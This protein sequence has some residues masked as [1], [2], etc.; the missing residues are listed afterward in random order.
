MARLWAMNVDFDS[1]A[2]GDT[3]PVLI[4]WETE[5]TIERYVSLHG[6]WDGE[7][8]AP[9]SLPPRTI[10]AYVVELLAK[11]FPAELL[12]SEGSDV[13]VEHLAPVVANDTVS[14]SGRVTGKRVDG[15]TR[16]VDCT[17][18]VENDRGETVA[19][20]QAIISM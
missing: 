18:T 7:E 9:Q 1:V 20:A 4:K 10:T 15:V 2:A 14:L 8:P 19:L 17:V 3:L 11:G 6:D 5:E 12:E 13:K 16:L